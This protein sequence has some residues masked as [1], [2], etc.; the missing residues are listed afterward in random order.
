MINNARLD[1]TSQQ[2]KEQRDVA[3]FCF[4]VFIY[5]LKTR[6]FLLQADASTQALCTGSH[7]RRGADRVKE[8]MGKMA[9]L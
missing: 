6:V 7:W 2:G 3:D 4:L 8:K 9:S 5:L 1:T